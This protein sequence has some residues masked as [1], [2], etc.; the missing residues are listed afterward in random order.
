MSK[1]WVPV[2]EYIT[3]LGDDICAALPFWYLFTGWDTDHHSVVGGR[4]CVGMF[5]NHIV[6]QHLKGNISHSCYHAL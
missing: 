4:K 2:H 6:I 3:S 1:R 5:R